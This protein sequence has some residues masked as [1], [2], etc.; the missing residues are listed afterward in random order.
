MRL[1]ITAH[2]PNGSVLLFSLNKQDYLDRSELDGKPFNI[3]CRFDLEP[4]VSPAGYWGTVI[5]VK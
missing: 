2:G 3:V 5:E 4:G 1:E